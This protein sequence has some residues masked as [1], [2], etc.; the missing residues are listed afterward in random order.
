[1][2]MLASTTDFI[3]LQPR[4]PMFCILG[5]TLHSHWSSHRYLCKSKFSVSHVQ[6]HGAWGSLMQMK[7]FANIFQD[8]SQNFM[9]LFMKKIIASTQIL[10]WFLCFTPLPMKNWDTPFLITPYP[11]LL[12]VFVLFHELRMQWFYHVIQMRDRTFPYSAHHFSILLRITNSVN[13][14]LLCPLWIH[15]P[16][17]L[18]CVLSSFFSMKFHVS[19]E[20]LLLQKFYAIFFF[21]NSWKNIE[22]IVHIYA[23]CTSFLEYPIFSRHTW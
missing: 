4:R 2:A 18:L 3:K 22:V 5:S 10:Q 8:P 17:I 19:P 12:Q 6:K 13:M 9:T 1:M 20:T 15:F 14:F 7:N 21:L 16:K 11:L 23:E